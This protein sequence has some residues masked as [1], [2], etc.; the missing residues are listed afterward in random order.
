M[1][2][3]SPFKSEGDRPFKIIKLKYEQNSRNFL[4]LHVNLVSLDFLDLLKGCLSKMISSEG[5]CLSEI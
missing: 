4:P 1:N 5:I 2:V 3:I